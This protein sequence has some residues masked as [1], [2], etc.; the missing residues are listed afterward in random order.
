M[1]PLPLIFLAIFNSILGLSLLFPV[2][3]PLG[4]ELRLTELQVGTLSAAYAFAQFLG[5][6]YWGRKSEELGRKPVL[7]RGVL[8]FGATFFAFGI[9]ARLGQERVL[10][11]QVLFLS[12]LAT[13]LVG[14]LYSSA[15]L[16]T[17]QAYVAD[18]TERADRTQ[19]MAVIGAAFGLGLI[20]GPGISALLA[21]FGLLLPVYLSASLALL[22]A[23]YI[24]LRV[25]EPARRRSG[26]TPELLPMATKVWALLAIAFAVTVASVSMEQTLGFYFQDRLRLSPAGTQRAVGVALVVYGVVAVLVQGFLVR[27]LKWSPG[28]LVRSGVPIAAAGLGLLVF[29][30]AEP[31]L[32]LSMAVQGFG[33]ALALPGITAAI[34][35]NVG[36]DEQGAV[37]GLNSSAQGFGRMIG[38]VLGTGLYQIRPEYPYAFGACLSLVV[39]TI[40]MLQRKAAW[41]NPTTSPPSL[42]T[43]DRLSP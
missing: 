13:R 6:P 28:R 15:T 9:L 24:K 42:E 40:L 5:S 41:S 19:G 12:L 35:L 36:P 14:G 32:V 33:Q 8:G 22:N 3:A 34:S 29:A 18:V 21:P 31:L 26:P 7:L 38:P 39:L 23:L 30:R 11:G 25:P 2:M 27:R 43:S 10:E 1:K 20:V 4:R 37:A 17:A 16:P